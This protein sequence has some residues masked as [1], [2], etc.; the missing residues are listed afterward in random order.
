MRRDPRGAGLPEPAPDRTASAGQGDLRDLD[1]RLRVRGDGIAVDA[2]GNGIL[3]NNV[4]RQWSGGGDQVLD[5]SHRQDADD[6]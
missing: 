1:G 4:I 5:L 2:P 6:D 3:F